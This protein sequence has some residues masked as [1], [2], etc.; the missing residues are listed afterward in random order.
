MTGQNEFSWDHIGKTF[1]E[2]YDKCTS[3]WVM[4]MDIDYFLHEE[5]KNKLFNAL[6]KY[7]NYDNFCYLNINFYTD[8]YQIKTRICLLFNKKK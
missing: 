4:R 6:E 2:G 1:Q 5:T 8:R 3:D 7:N